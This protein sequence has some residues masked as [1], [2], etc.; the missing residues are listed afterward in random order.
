MLVD[1]KRYRLARTSRWL[2]RL[3]IGLTPK[4]DLTFVLDVDPVAC[5]L[6]K[7][8]LTI[9]ELVRQRKQLLTLAKE[10]KSWTV[11]DANQSPAIVADQVCRKIVDLL[12][13]RSKSC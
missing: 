1:G 3:I 4:S 9:P 11:I 2:A 10:K 5:H 8:E 6:R 13:K 7:P 12:I